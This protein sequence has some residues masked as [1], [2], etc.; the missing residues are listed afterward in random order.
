MQ[1]TGIDRNSDGYSHIDPAYA[2]FGAVCTI[3]EGIEAAVAVKWG[4]NTTAPEYGLT[5]GMT[6]NF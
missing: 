3:R 4:L 2:L 5:A 1:N 6:F